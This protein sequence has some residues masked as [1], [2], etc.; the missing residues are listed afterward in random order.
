MQNLNEATYVDN[1]NVEFELLF[2]GFYNQTT[3]EFNVTATLVADITNLEHQEGQYEW[4]VVGKDAATIDSAGAAY[5]TQ[6]FD[7][8]KQIHVRMTGLDI[9]DE[10]YGVNAPYVMAGASTGT[11]T[12]YYY[13]YAAVDLRSALRDDWCN[14]N[15]VAS[16]NMLFTGGPRANLGT[17]YFNEFTM[18]MYAANEWIVTDIGHKDKIYAI[19]CW[20]RHSYGSG[21]A[22]IS[23]YKD[24]NGTIGF[25]I[26]G[27]DGQD[28]YFATKWFWDTGIYYLQQENCGVTDIILKITYP[29]YDPIHPSFSIVERLGTISHKPQHDCPVEEI[30]V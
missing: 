27:M 18:A 21:Y 28:T 20:D 14:S 10:L 25:L 24:L 11:R 13:D 29:A 8:K 19:S 23:V 17:E 30:P 4:M 26:W 16:S 12:D 5:I 7:S 3:D 1:I 15:P 9:R 22:A 6:A 2:S